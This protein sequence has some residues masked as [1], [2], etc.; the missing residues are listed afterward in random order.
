MRTD[1][2]LEDVILIIIKFSSVIYKEMYGSL[3]GELLIRS[4][5]LLCQINVSILLKLNKTLTS[6][7]QPLIIGIK[8]MVILAQNRL[9]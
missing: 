7:V 1:K 6:P 4:G 8:G 2:Q 3:N 9:S 5:R